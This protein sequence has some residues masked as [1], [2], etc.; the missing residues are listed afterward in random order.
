MAINLALKFS[1]KLDERYKHN[2]FTDAW[3]GNTYEWEGVNAIKVYTINTGKLN[4]YDATKTANRF[5]TPHEVEDEVN[6]Y[7]LRRK[8]SFSETID[9][10]N[11]QDQLFLK[12]ASNYLKQMW[13]YAYVPEMD[14]YRLHTWAEGAGLGTLNSTALG[15]ATVVK[16]MLTGLTALD[17]A[18]VPFEGRVMYVRSDIAIEYRLADEFKADGLGE[19]VIKRQIGDINGTP[20]VAVPPTFMPKGVVFLIKHK[21]ATADPTKLKTLRAHENPPGIAGVLLEG[22]VRYDSFVLAQKADGIYV[23]ASDATAVCAAPTFSIASNKVT[24]ESTASGATIK[25]TTD[26]T[27][28]KTSDTAKVYS[29]AVD[30]SADTTFRA[31]ASKTGMLSSPITAYDAV[32]A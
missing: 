8:R 15:K 26:G 29:A 5:G 20:V 13:D 21:Q 7:Q 31:Y 32:K 24:I 27:N 19:R 1:P 17:D 2:S 22:L 11:T 6:T 25:Y 9:V 14:K 23:Y 16:A 10:T 28:P 4:D 18:G 3:C 30:I 12:K